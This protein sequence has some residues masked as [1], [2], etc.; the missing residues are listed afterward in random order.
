LSRVCELLRA[1]VHAIAQLLRARALIGELLRLDVLRAGGGRQAI[2]N[3]VERAGELLLRRGL[4]PR[5][6]GRSRCRVAAAAFRI[7]GRGAHRIG[8]ALHAI[9]KLLP[10]QLLRADAGSGGHSRRLRRFVRRLATVHR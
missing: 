6:V 9:G 8:G 3:L 10:P 5:I 1:V 2:G 7:L 4:R